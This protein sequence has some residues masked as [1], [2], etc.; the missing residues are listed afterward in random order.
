M[1]RCEHEKNKYYKPK[2]IEYFKYNKQIF[3]SE[4]VLILNMNEDNDVVC[5]CT[6]V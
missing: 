4:I 2:L 6:S 5:G 1:I 3:R